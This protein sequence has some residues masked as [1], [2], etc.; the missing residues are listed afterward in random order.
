MAKTRIRTTPE[1]SPIFQ[2]VDDFYT[3]NT[4]ANACRRYADELR[5]TLFIRMKEEGLEEVTTPNGLQAFIACPNRLEVDG[6]ILLDMILKGKIG[7][8]AAIEILSS[9]S[10]KS[11]TDNAGGAVTQRVTISGK[12]TENVSVKVAK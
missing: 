4:E 2:M 7:T 10:L 3:A 5:K 1:E 12:G 8:E 11:I 9:V 6:K